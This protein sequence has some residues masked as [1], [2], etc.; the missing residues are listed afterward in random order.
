MPTI[1]KFYRVWFVGVGGFWR[2]LGGCQGLEGVRGWVGWKEGRAGRIWVV[3]GLARAYSP[4]VSGWAGYWGC[5]P[6]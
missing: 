4:L 3:W 2:G 1:L 6:G 5:A